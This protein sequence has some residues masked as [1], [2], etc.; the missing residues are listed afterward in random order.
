MDGETFNTWNKIAGLYEQKFMSVSLYD[1]T[2]DSFLETLPENASVLDIGCGPGNI[3]KFLLDNKP[4]LNLL[5]IDMAPGMIALARKNN[6]R[7]NF[8]VMDCKNIKNISLE[9]NGIISGFVIP[10]VSHAEMGQFI[11]D[12]SGLLKN[13]GNF[14]VSFVD[15][16]PENSGM[17]SNS[18]GDRTIFHYHREPD[19]INLMDRA[20]LALQKTFYIDYPKNGKTEIH[21]VLIAK[22]ISAPDR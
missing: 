5:G 10:Y 12:A 17:I 2:Y 11:K 20:G 4:D 6:P 7:G 8:E 14:Y 19:I 16:N 22:K 9:F 15:G 18:E 13:S 3:S 21:T 1:H